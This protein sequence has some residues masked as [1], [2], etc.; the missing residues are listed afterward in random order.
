MRFACSALIIVLC[1]CVSGWSE[2]GSEPLLVV[3][4]VHWPG[5]DLTNA[6]VR[7]FRDPQRQELVG[8][9]PALDTSGRCV[10]PLEQGEYYLMAVVDVDGDQALSPGDGMG[11]YG[12]VDPTTSQPQP[13]RIT[14]DTSEV[15]IVISLMM[16]TERK[17]SLTG[18][19]EPSPPPPRRALNMAG[20][21][22]GAAEQGL[23]CVYFVPTEGGRCFAAAAMLPAGEFRATILDGEYYLFAAQDVSGDEVIGEGDLVAVPGYKAA[24][25]E[26][27]PATE[28]AEDQSELR[29]DLT[30]RVGPDGLLQ[31]REGQATGPRVALDTLPA[32][33][34]GEV[35]NMPS[36][37]GEG[38]EAPGPTTPGIARAFQD[39]TLRKEVGFSRFAGPRFALC[40]PTGTYFVTVT[41]DHDADARPTPGDQLGFYGV[42]DLAKSHGPQPLMLRPAELRPV[43][44]PLVA[45]LNAELKP[46][47]NTTV[48]R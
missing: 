1:A 17:L 2:D 30:W 34:L 10:L 4:R 41:A 29:L 48:P 31:A 16:D 8:S 26:A 22:A 11:F 46:E 33:V 14:A 13:C 9:F 24:Q 36:A 3:A 37:D 28:L 18:V 21:V 32:V 47:A 23:I 38:A 20:T 39:A 43:Q 42:T 7:V 44:I 5:Q 40:V 45:T 12:V 19:T 15:L 25:G 35:L 27:F 6:Q